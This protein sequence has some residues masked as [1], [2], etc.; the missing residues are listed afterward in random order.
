MA[1]LKMILLA[2]ARKL[3][4]RCIAGIEP[5]TGKWIRPVKPGGGALSLADICYQDGSHP[6]LLDIV[7]VPVINKEPLYY[8]PENWI[9]DEDIYWS[10][11]G[12]V[13]QK[14]LPRYCFTE[15]YIF[16]DQ[17]DRL[18]KY[19]CEQIGISYSLML[20][21]PE[22]V[23]FR[24]TK[25]ATNKPQLRA[26]F[27]YNDIL[28]NLVVTDPEWESRYAVAEDDD[29]PLRRE[30]LFTISLGEAFEGCHYKLIAAVIEYQRGSPR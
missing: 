13:D 28:Y 6:K 22:K 1:V 17:N 5:D 8:Q 25:S 21:K 19:R 11:L 24:K 27:C 26:L 18:A 4:E 7:R 3:G 15:R 16:F 20:V 30:C 2:N 12:V 23:I 10:R 14:L 29:Y 9:V